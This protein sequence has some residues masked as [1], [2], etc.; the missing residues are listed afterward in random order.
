[1][2]AIVTTLL[3]LLSAPPASAQSA[4]DFTDGIG[5]YLQQ[6]G[7]Y[8][9]LVWMTN[10]GTALVT[11]LAEN[12][13]QGA[14]IG[15]PVKRDARLFNF[16]IDFSRA[17]GVAPPHFSLGYCYFTPGADKKTADQIAHGVFPIRVK[18]INAA[19]G[20]FASRD[21]QLPVYEMVLPDFTRDPNFGKPGPLLWAFT[22]Q[23]N[24]DRGWL[25]RYE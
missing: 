5:Y 4:K 7:K 3:L 25:F 10:L 22:L 11:A 9:L 23:N 24:C 8:Q 15:L 14:S 6:S 17:T 21:D 20:I 16:G 2:R 12:P 18:I 19:S 1:M 13:A